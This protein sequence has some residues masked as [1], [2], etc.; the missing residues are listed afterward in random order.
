MVIL[1]L[2]LLDM[3]NNIMIKVIQVIVLPYIIYKMTQV[4]MPKF[5]IYLFQQ[6]LE[7]VLVLCI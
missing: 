7:V 3:L 2:E 4:C 1:Y 5:L 6:V